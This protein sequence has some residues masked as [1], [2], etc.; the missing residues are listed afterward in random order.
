MCKSNK[1]V[2]QKVQDYYS[3]KSNGYEPQITSKDLHASERNKILLWRIDWKWEKVQTAVV[4]GKQSY[5]KQ[6]TGK[7]ASREQ[8]NYKK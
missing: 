7:P 4:N 6:K 8:R 5:E 3:I 2:S 1:N